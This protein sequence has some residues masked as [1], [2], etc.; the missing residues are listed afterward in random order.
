MRR[1]RLNREDRWI[2]GVL[3]GLGEYFGI[4]PLVLRVFYVFLTIVSGDKMLMFIAAYFLV[5]LV[6]LNGERR[7]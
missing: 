3:G 6:I 5:Y 7:K 2:F 4:D 1:L